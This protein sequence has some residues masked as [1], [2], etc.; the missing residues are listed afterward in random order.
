MTRMSALLALALV[1]GAAAPASA[2]G[3]GEFFRRLN[4]A[5]LFERSAPED[6]RPELPGT[7]RLREI[8]AERGLD[9]AEI[10]ERIAKIEAARENGMLKRQAVL[11]ARRPDLDA[12]RARLEERGLSETEIDERIGRIEDALARR[13][14]GRPDMAAGEMPDLERLRAKL[15]ERGIDATLIDERIARIEGALE[16]RGQTRGRPENTPRNAGVDGDE[17]R[18]RMPPVFQEI[19]PADVIP[20]TAELADSGSAAGSTSATN[21]ELEVTMIPAMVP[22]VVDA[23]EA[24]GEVI[25]ASGTLG[26][27]PPVRSIFDRN[28]LRERMQAR[29]MTQE[30]IDQRLDRI[31]SKI[32]NR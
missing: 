19:I 5:R 11:E 13:Q 3:L 6:R 32:R 10:D 29:G 4:P 21:R 7:D 16:R 12:L 8:L 27:V 26:D 22:R 2:D 9:E 30:Q 15:E 28:H 31:S 14:A 20:A 25:Q 1:L 17:V 24:P 23:A 18:L